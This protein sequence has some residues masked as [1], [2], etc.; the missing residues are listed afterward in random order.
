VE[1]L[2]G[3]A[4][5]TMAKKTTTLWAAIALGLLWSSRHIPVIDYLGTAVFVSATKRAASKLS[6]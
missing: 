1:E 4:F 6:A 3:F 2:P 5:P